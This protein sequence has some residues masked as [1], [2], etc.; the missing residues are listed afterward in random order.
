MVADV[1]IPP[2]HYHGY[3]HQFNVAHVRRTGRNLPAN[4]YECWDCNDF[5]AWYRK[6]HPEF[7]PQEAA[8]NASIIVPAT[9]YTRIAARTSVPTTSRIVANPTTSRIVAKTA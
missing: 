6:R 9:T 5:L 4:G 1:N 7:V 3:A 8:R 2:I